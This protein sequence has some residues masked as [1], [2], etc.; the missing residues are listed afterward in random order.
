[1]LDF[2]KL[3]EWLGSA[4][5]FTLGRISPAAVQRAHIEYL[6]AQLK[7]AEK[8]VN[9]PTATTD[10]I[11]DELRQSEVLNASLVRQVEGYEQKERDVNN[12]PDQIEREQKR[13]KTLTYDPF[14][15]INPR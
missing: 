13:I 8:K 10:T 2:T 1:M 12:Q 11:R 7:A 6:N 15:H 5:G 9:D 3:F 14:E 4:F